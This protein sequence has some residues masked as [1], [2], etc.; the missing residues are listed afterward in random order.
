MT[1]LQGL[2]SATSPD[3]GGHS[4]FSPVLYSGGTARHYAGSTADALN[5]LFRLL[6]KVTFRYAYRGCLLGS[7]TIGLRSSLPSAKVFSRKR[8]SPSCTTSIL[9]RFFAIFGM[10]LDGIER[11]SKKNIGRARSWQKTQKMLVGQSGVGNG[12][13]EGNADADCRQETG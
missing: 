13:A 6:S 9:D 12:R 4:H 3:R 2:G 5:A 8:S 1:S 7:F 11:T 10:P